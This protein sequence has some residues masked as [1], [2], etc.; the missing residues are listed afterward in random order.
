M[1]KDEREDGKGREGDGKQIL[2]KGRVSYKWSFL[3]SENDGRI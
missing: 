3:E 1:R 2:T